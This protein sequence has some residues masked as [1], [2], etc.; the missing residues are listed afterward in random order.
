LGDDAEGGT[1]YTDG[2]WYIYNDTTLSDGTWA[3]NGSVYV[4]NGTLTLDRAELVL[5]RTGPYISN[6]YVGMDAHLVS[7]S[8]EIWGNSTGILIE[9]WGDTYFDNTSI[10]DLYWHS[11]I[12][13]ID[14]RQGSLTLDHCQLDR[15]YYTI[16][17]SGDLTVRSGTGYIGPLPAA[18]LVIPLSLLTPRSRTRN[19]PTRDMASGSPRAV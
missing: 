18:I 2:D 19:S 8:S 14:H 13:G 1:T 15:A 7:R 17:S 11:S 6:L 12:G 10:H 16:T 5:N 9:V 3:V 4:E